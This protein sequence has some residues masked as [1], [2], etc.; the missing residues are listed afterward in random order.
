MTTYFR[1]LALA[2]AVLASAPVAAQ[3]QRPQG[4]QATS[5]NQQAERARDRCK[6]N[7]GVDCDTAEGLKEWLLLE[8]SREEAVQEGSRHLLPAQPR[9]A[10]VRSAPAR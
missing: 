3:T 9:P 5:K 8:R 4:E 10:P 1:T 2:L 6:L 7:H